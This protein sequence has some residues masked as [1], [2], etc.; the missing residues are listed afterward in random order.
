MKGCRTMWL[1]CAP[2]HVKR[3]IKNSS[4]P[5]LLTLPP[6]IWGRKNACVQALQKL[7]K[8]YWVAGSLPLSATEKL[9]AQ[10]DCWRL[11]VSVALSPPKNFLCLRRWSS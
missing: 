8:S 9:M 11:L 10:N 6:K 4:L 1:R 5:L 2:S 7:R 3:P